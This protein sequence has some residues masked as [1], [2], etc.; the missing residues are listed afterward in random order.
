LIIWY[1]VK[2]ILLTP[3]YW[4]FENNNKTFLVHI[5]YILLIRFIICSLFFCST[6]F[7]VGMS[8]KIYSNFMQIFLYNIKTKKL[9][10]VNLGNFKTHGSYFDYNLS[11]LIIFV[12]HYLQIKQSNT[13]SF[14]LLGLILISCFTWVRFNTKLLQ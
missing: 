9:I 12:L 11:V 3:P 1:V 14:L 13:R 4:Y 7:S 6:I 2:S 5:G 8:K 10:F